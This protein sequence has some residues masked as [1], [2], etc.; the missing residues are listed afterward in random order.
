MPFSQSAK[1]TARPKC[2]PSERNTPSVL[3][4]NSPLTVMTL[5][6]VRQRRPERDRFIEPPPIVR[7]SKKKIDNGEKNFSARGPQGVNEMGRGGIEPSTR[8]FSVRPE[9]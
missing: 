1:M 9:D 7:S 5:R 8:G 3:R 4:G 6:K 2:V